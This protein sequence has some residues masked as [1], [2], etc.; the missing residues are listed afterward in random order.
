MNKHVHAIFIFIGV[1]LLSSA[2]LQGIMVAGEHNIARTVD[3]AVAETS[4]SHSG[5]ATALLAQRGMTTKEDPFGGVAASSDSAPQQT[6]SEAVEEPAEV[7]PPTICNIY[8][9]QPGLG[10]V[11]PNTF[12]VS[13]YVDN[14]VADCRWTIF[15][16]NAGGIEVYDNAGNLLSQY[17]ILDSVGDWMQFPSYFQ[18]LVTLVQTPQTEGGYIRFY[19][20]VADE[21]TPDIFDYPISFTSH[22]VAP[23]STGNSFFDALGDFF[24][25]KEQKAQEEAQRQKQVEQDAYVSVDDIFGQDGEIP[26]IQ[27][28]E[29]VSDRVPVTKNSDSY[30]E[31]RNQSRLVCYGEY[32]DDTKEVCGCRVFAGLE[33]YRVQQGFENYSVNLDGVMFE[34]TLFIGDRGDSVENLQKALYLLGY[35]QQLP[36]RVYDM[37]TV[38]AVRAF[39]AENDLP[40]WGLFVGTKS[41]IVLTTLFSN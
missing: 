27:I 30:C 5:V 1:V 20:H 39:Q 40:G 26:K 34:K 11:V 29:I 13:G 21:S 16:A 23:D 38:S 32:T 36:S 3:S 37:T 8:V 22:Q 24:K 15:E 14:I 7:I 31:V 19:E 2:F 41:N 12:V 6:F 33:S 9:T 25:S 4:L 18:S 28:P 35:Y 10:E 17:Y